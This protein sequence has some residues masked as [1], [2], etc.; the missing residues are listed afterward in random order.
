MKRKW[1]VAIAIYLGLIATCLIAIYAVPSVRGML[2]KTYIAEYGSIDV[3]DEVSAFIVRDETVYVSSEP[4]TINRLADADKLVKANT[5]VVELTPDTEASSAEVTDKGENVDVTTENKEKSYGKY[6]DILKELGDSV[7]AT[8]GYNTSAGYVSYYV[9]GAEAKLSTDAL[10]SITY[11]DYKA[12]TGRKAIEVPKKS[13]GEGYPIF[14]VVKNAKWYLVFYISN[15]KAEKY[16]PG[17]TVIIDANGTDVE[18]T[19]SQVL[20]GRKYSKVTLSCKSFFD[21]FFKARN[22]DTTVTL[23]RA[24]GLVLEDSSI[25]EDPNGQIGVFVKNKLG[26]HIFTPVAIKADNGTQCVV[27]SDMY[28][29]AEGNYVETIGTYDEIIS[30]PSEEDMANLK[31]AVEKAAAEEAA[32]KAAAE[33][34]AAEQAAAEKAATE[35]AAAEEATKAEQ[36][37]AA[38]EGSAEETT[39]TEQ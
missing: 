4:S 32:E 9:D 25:V 27:Y 28:V 30:E 7:K 14:K 24:E 13:C 37:A 18:V 36:A 8:D 15:K 38:E 11:K 2:E 29:D 31:A 1:I 20:A 16:V 34:A 6:T 3:K 26:E 17:E 35:Q 33:K 19:V 39:E 21:G 23:R 22:L 10:D 5:H 12:L